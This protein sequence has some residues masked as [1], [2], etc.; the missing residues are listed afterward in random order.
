M[1]KYAT[2]LLLTITIAHADAVRDYIVQWEGY[3]SEVYICP[4]G[5]P[6]VGVG[7]NLSFETQ[8]SKYTAADIERYYLTDITR[9]QRIADKLIPDFA[10]LPQDAQLV[11]LSVIFTVG[12]AGF[13][14]FKKYRKAIASNDYKQAAKELRN[15]LWWKQVSPQRAKEHFMRLYLINHDPK[16]PLF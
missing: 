6:A 5:K 7:H 1:L 8:K 16:D 9:T 14:K 10:T 3:K 11:T 4:S 12:E 15:S 13:S 2:L